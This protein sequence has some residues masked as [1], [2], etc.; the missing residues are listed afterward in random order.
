MYKKNLFR[1]TCAYLGVIIGTFTV[2]LFMKGNIEHLFWKLKVVA[3]GYI[4]CI[5]IMT[6]ILTIWS[7]RKNH[8]AKS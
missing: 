8:K 1:G 7:P 2:E 6:I 3:A 4:I 5:L